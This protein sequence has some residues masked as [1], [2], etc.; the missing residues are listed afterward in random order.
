MEMQVIFLGI[1]E[2]QSMGIEGQSQ[3]KEHCTYIRVI[4]KIFTEDLLFTVALFQ[5][6]F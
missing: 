4:L 2:G 5:A 3:N 6:L 1:R